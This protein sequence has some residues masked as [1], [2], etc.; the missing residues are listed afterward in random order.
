MTDETLLKITHDKIVNLVKTDLDNNA[1]QWRHTDYH[2]CLVRDNAQALGLINDKYT[3]AVQAIRG[4]RGTVFVEVLIPGQDRPK[5]IIFVK[6][7]QNDL[8]NGV[9][10]GW[11]AAP[12]QGYVDI[13]G[14]HFNA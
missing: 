10:G 14:A 2:K 12:S 1:A 9:R 6:I 5:T 3:I 8:P 13:T 11:G 4:A 7:E